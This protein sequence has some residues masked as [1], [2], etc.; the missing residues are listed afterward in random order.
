[1]LKQLVELPPVARVLAP[2]MVRR[3]EN[4]IAELGEIVSELEVCCDNEK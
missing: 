4:S 2:D 3:A 1:M